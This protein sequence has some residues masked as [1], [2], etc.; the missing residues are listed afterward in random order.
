MNLNDLITLAKIMGNLDNDQFQDKATHIIGYGHIKS[1]IDCY[2]AYLGL[3]NFEFATTYKRKT[4]NPDM[5]LK[6]YLNIEDFEEGEYLMKP[7]VVVF[8]GKNM[9][10]GNKK[11]FF[12]TDFK[13]MFST[14]NLTRILL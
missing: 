6:E 10:G 3:T 7:K 11:Y 14:V 9:K 13:E 5:S 4:K 1:F 12:Y 2:F 8:Q